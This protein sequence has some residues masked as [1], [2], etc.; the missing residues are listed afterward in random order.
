MRPFLLLLPLSVLALIAAVL[1]RAMIWVG[2]MDQP[3]GRKAHAR[4]TPKAGGIAVI[5]A[6]LAGGLLLAPLWDMRAG[7]AGG[8]ALGLGVVGLLDDVRDR[9]VGV[10][11]AA[12]I[13]AAMLVASLGNGDPIGWALSVLWLV[14]ITNM[15]N[16]M[17]GLDGLAG[18]TGLIAALFLAAAAPHGGPT[19]A[20]ALALAAGL[21]GFLPFN[22]APARLFLGD[23]GS[24]FC[25]FLLGVLGLGL[26]QETAMAHSFWLLP[27]LLAGMI[28]DVGLTLCRRLLAGARLTQAHREHFYQR[29]P[30]PAW[31]VAAVHWGFATLGGAAG[32]L[33]EAGLVLPV[34]LLP[35]LAWLGFVHRHGVRIPA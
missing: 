28:F 23:T 19:Q 16:F 22:L 35:Q 29:A 7:I 4:P 25:G 24:Q 18:G 30:L 6:C 12:Q 34:L 13:A 15:F 17:D 20:G 2:I 5:G 33:M 1:A 27:A 10:K 11:L 31:A 21:A 9:G 8:A 32:L 14:G 26:W 3:A